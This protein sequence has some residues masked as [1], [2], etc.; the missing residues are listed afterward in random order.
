MK[1][2]NKCQNNILGV[3]GSLLDLMDLKYSTDWYVLIKND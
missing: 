2:M 3:G 1:K